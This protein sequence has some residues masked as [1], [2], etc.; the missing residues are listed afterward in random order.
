M[1]RIKRSI[2]RIPH[3]KPRKLD[4]AATQPRRGQREVQRTEMVVGQFAVL[5]KLSGLG[6]NARPRCKL[7][8]VRVE[9]VFRIEAAQ[10]IGFRSSDRP[11][12]SA[13]EYEML[14]CANV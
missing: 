1:I 9:R 7:L 13:C 10:G 8:M 3:R 4:D 2:D 5:H 14:I 11:T 12:L 6:S